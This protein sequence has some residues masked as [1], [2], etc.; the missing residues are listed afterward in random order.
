MKKKPVDKK[1]QD[2]VDK[3]VQEFKPERVI[4]FGSHAWGEPTE[5][6]DVDLLVVGESDKPRRE[7]QQELRS[8]VRPTGVPLDLLVYTPHELTERIQKDRNLFLEDIVSNG[9]VLYANI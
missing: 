5:D 6:S 4:L 2:V 1:I 3:I 7:R 8:S 9:T